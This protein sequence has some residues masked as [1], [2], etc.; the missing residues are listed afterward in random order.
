MLSQS[1]LQDLCPAAVPFYTLPEGG[2]E[3]LWAMDR[4]QEGHKGM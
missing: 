3:A 1:H 2:P 4:G